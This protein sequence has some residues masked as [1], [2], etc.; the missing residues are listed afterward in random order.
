MAK[1]E[2]GGH[3]LHDAYDYLKTPLGTVEW[4][5][6]WGEPFRSEAWAKWVT[7]REAAPLLNDGQET[8]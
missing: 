7:D 2:F 1:G 3:Q 4:R 8:P 6:T 5:V